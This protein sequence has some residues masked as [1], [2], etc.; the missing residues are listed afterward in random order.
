M[1]PANVTERGTP[2]NH[3]STEHLLDLLHKSTGTVQVKL[4][5]G[6]TLTG[7]AKVLAGSGTATVTEGTT[8]WTVAGPAIAAV[9]V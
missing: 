6:T 2:M 8:T 4:L 3:I 5:D 9:A 1:T 7:K